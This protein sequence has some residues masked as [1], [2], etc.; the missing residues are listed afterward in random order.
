MIHHSSTAV[1]LDNHVQA[2]S[3]LTHTSIPALHLILQHS[4]TFNPLSTV[5]VNHS[6]P[7]LLATNRCRSS[8]RTSGDRALNC[9]SRESPQSLSAAPS[10]K[11]PRSPQSHSAYLL[12]LPG[13][14]ITACWK[15]RAC[16]HRSYLNEVGLLGLNVVGMPGPTKLSSPSSDASAAVAPARS[17]TVCASSY[18]RWEEG[19]TPA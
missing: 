11:H 12:W 1:L 17:R 9:L 6:Y 18:G 13:H 2:Q 7:R 16:K 3:K 15:S 5:R 10:A 8:N 4:A 14:M 19:M